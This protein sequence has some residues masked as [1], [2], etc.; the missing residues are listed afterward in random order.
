MI[1]LFG[2]SSL[3]PPKPSSR[4]GFRGWFIRLCRRISF[5]V[6]LLL[7]L[8]VVAII[9]F[10]WVPVPFSS[11]M[12]IRQVERLLPGSEVPPMHYQWVNLEDISPLM[13]LAVIAGEDQRFPDHW[14]F[15]FR[16][17]SQALDYNNKHSRKMR[18]AS[19]ISQQTA[20]NLFLWGERS[21]LRKGLEAGLTLC[22]EIVWSKERILEIYLNIAEFGDGIYGVKAASKELFTTSPAR[23]T[24]RQV[25]LLAAVLPNPRRFHANH[26]TPYILNRARWIESNMGRLGGTRYLEQL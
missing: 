18:G 1:R 20:K 21:L 14:G 26:P 13:P 6:V 5:F 4:R 17:I 7:L 16:A 15:D 23:L 8:P 24:R 12:L 10:R 3:S 11:F 9:A 2:R 19:T 25:A 22:M